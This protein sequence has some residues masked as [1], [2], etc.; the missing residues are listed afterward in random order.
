MEENYIQKTGVYDYAIYVDTRGSKQLTSAHDLTVAVAKKYKM[1]LEAV[2]R[3]L[4]PHLNIRIVNIDTDHN[5]CSLYRFEISLSQS[6]SR[7]ETG[8]IDLL[9]NVLKQSLIY[10]GMIDPEMC[11]KTVINEFVNR[12]SANLGLAFIDNEQISTMRKSACEMIAV[13]NRTNFTLKANKFWSSQDREA[14]GIESNGVNRKIEKAKTRQRSLLDDE[15][16]PVKKSEEEPLDE[17]GQLDSDNKTN[18][19]AFEEIEANLLAQF[20]YKSGRY[21]IRLVLNGTAVTALYRCGSEVQL[22]GLIKDN[23]V[24]DVVLKVNVNNRVDRAIEIHHVK[25]VETDET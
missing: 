20:D 21:V 19:P 18:E 13:V 2:E 10:K 5:F 23:L 7:H 3:S 9:F 12:A 16:Y 22:L 14:D 8:L 17:E 15:L 24:R 4:H 1:F 25:A 6:H 11:S